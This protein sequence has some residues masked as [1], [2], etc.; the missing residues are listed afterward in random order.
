MPFSA[1][2]RARS[3][4]TSASAKVKWSAYSSA[5]HE[6]GYWADAYEKL[7]PE[8]RALASQERPLAESAGRHSG[9]T[10]TRSRLSLVLSTETTACVSD[11]ALRWLAEVK[12]KCVPFF[13]CNSK[14]PP[15]FICICLD[16]WLRCASDL[17]D[18]YLALG[19]SSQLHRQ[20]VLRGVSIK[21]YRVPLRAVRPWTSPAR[22]LPGFSGR[23]FGARRPDLF[24]RLLTPYPPSP[25]QV[26]R[27]PA[28]SSGVGFPTTVLC[29]C[30]TAATTS[31]PP[32]SVRVRWLQRTPGNP[33]ADMPSVAFWHW[34]ASDRNVRVPSTEVS[35]TSGHRN[36][37]ARARSIIWSAGASCARNP[38]WEA[39]ARVRTPTYALYPGLRLPVASSIQHPA[40]HSS[41]LRTA[42]R[43]FPRVWGRRSCPS[44]S[45]LARTLPHVG[46]RVTSAPPPGGGRRPA[47]A[48]SSVEILE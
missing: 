17:D 10:A 46:G 42:T 30:S 9:R 27:P 4:S 45:P 37:L 14:C 15:I 13:A 2:L 41:L 29:V 16:A 47:S 20:A 8:A 25:R 43:A 39:L 23:G 11:A 34:Q 33:C 40:S 7:R 24:H 28:R 31:A 44:H 22:A 32:S 3:S 6:H 36:V 26:G 12:S 48:T 5:L 19:T 21:N 18:I 1:P 35:T 38:T